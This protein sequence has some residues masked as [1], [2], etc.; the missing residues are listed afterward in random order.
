MS[1]PRL[2]LPITQC[3]CTS[4]LSLAVLL[5]FVLLSG[6]QRRIAAFRT[7]TQEGRFEIFGGIHLQRLAK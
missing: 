1:M 4:S 5:A 3:K 6:K 7:C 2:L